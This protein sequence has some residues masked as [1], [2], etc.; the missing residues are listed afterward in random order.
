MGDIFLDKN[1][2]LVTTDYMSSDVFNSN[3]IEYS[4]HAVTTNITINMIDTSIPICVFDILQ[5]RK[6]KS[7]NKDDEYGFV[8]GRVDKNGVFH[9]FSREVIKISFKD[10]EI[11]SMQNI[12][13]KRI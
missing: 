10:A 12:P 2:D 3:S 7:K 1:M 4:A 5:V 8:L 6:N 13:F 9:M 11:F